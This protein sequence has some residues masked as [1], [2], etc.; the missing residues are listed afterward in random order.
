MKITKNELRTIIKEEI[1]KLSELVYKKGDKVKVISSDNKGKLG[2]VISFDPKEK[3]GPAVFPGGVVKVKL[4]GSP[5]PYLYTPGDLMLVETKKININSVSNV[6]KLSDVLERMREFDKYST[7]LESEDEPSFENIPMDLLNN[8]GLSADNLQSI[9][10][11]TKKDE[12][13]IE[14]HKDKDNTIS[15]WPQIAE[16][17]LYDVVDNIPDSISN[18][19]EVD[20]EVTYLTNEDETVDLAMIMKDN[21]KVTIGLYKAGGERAIK[22][23]ERNIDSPKRAADVFVKAFKQYD[24][25]YKFTY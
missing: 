4:D 3:Q 22:V 20:D 19:L 24:K 5:S 6:R 13:I 21:M 7:G 11:K 12:G 16:M 15:I 8:H 25:Q 23:I 9:A 14:F 1:K 18:R 17:D 2:T 10:K